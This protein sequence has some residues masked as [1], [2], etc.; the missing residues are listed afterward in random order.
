M[1][2]LYSRTKSSTNLKFGGKQV[3]VEP[4][5]EN[6]SYFVEGTQFAS[7]NDLAL[8]LNGKFYKV[9]KHSAIPV[10]GCVKTDIGF[11]GLCSVV[12]VS[13]NRNSI[14]WTS[15][16]IG[17]IVGVLAFVSVNIMKPDQN[18]E[19]ASNIGNE[20][21]YITIIHQIVQK[22]R[23]SGANVIFDT[24][25]DSS[26][27]SVT[28]ERERPP[29]PTNIDTSELEAE[30]AKETVRTLENIPLNVPSGSFTVDQPLFIIRN[31][32]GERIKVTVETEGAI[33][34]TS[35]IAENS[36]GYFNVYD[37]LLME[38][39]YLDVSIEGEN[40]DEHYSIEVWL[41]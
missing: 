37:D 41:K 23:G 21:E 22:V 11:I 24:I 4:K 20:P 15:I 35:Y 25:D 8:E 12:N 5:L 18:I 36:L 13:K 29:K 1:E 10:A 2:V 31:T 9:L 16:V 32:T 30:L 27:V 33:V 3:Q 28:S 39:N 38:D 26:D 7:D 17:V 19:V 34:W 6:C 14:P 40:I